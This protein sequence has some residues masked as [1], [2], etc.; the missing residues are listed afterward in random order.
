MSF[1][2][3]SVAAM[4]AIPPHPLASRLGMEP[5]AVGTCGAGVLFAD[6]FRSTLGHCF[7]A[8]HITLQGRGEL[9]LFGGR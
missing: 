6:D 3:G 8:G 7:T 5:Y 1:F 2:S 4:G 9:G